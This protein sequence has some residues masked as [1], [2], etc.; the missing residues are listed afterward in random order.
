MPETDTW[1]DRCKV[2]LREYI[3]TTYTLLPDPEVPPAYELEVVWAVPG[4]TNNRMLVRT[5]IGDFVRYLV[6][7]NLVEDTDNIVIEAFVDGPME[8]QTA[9]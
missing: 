9:V 5:D 4:E 7:H 6:T 3:N 8:A 2:V 1:I